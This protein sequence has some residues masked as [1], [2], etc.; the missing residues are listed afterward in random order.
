MTT[1]SDVDVGKGPSTLL[2]MKAQLHSVILPGSSRFGKICQSA[3]EG[4]IFP[5]EKMKANDPEEEK[6]GIQTSSRNS[7]STD[8]S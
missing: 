1:R 7:N 4:L 6:L 2:L 3:W 5:H 8:T